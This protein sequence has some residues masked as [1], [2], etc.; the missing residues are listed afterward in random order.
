M[1]DGG[2]ESTLQAMTLGKQLAGSGHPFKLK[3][4]HSSKSKY[5]KSSTNNVRF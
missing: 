5:H 3:T 4:F 1:T 2:I